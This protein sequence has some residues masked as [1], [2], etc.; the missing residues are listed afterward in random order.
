MARPAAARFPAARAPAALGRAGRGPGLAPGRLPEVDGAVERRLQP[1][2][3]A[4]A[5]AVERP[6]V[7]WDGRVLSL[8]ALRRAVL[9]RRAHPALE[10]ARPVRHAVPREQP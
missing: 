5:A 7:G 9:R 10:P 4:G 8:E 1:A 3:A 2:G 6:P